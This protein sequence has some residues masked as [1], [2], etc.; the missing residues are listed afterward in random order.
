MI[1][2]KRVRRRKREQPKD[3]VECLVDRVCSFLAWQSIK[4]FG[5]SLLSLRLKMLADF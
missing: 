5:A 3:A 1:M 2:Q 4:F